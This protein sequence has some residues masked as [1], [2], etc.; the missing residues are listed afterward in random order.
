MSWAELQ[1]VVGQGGSEGGED[2]QAGRSG[3]QEGICQ[4]LLVSCKHLKILGRCRKYLSFKLKNTFKS[5]NMMFFGGWLTNK[6]EDKCLTMWPQFC[7]V[8]CM[9][10]NSPHASG[11]GISF[12][13]GRLSG[14][15]QGNLF[16]RFF[17]PKEIS[18]GKVQESNS[19]AYCSW[20]IKWYLGF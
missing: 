9:P 6:R 12:W 15:K 18:V 7:E 19:R 3:R 14:G 5:S 13:T 10:S 16:K 4:S 17:A 2:P 11:F 1:E 20:I 8:C